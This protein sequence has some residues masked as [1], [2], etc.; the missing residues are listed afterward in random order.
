MNLD[1]LNG[2]ALALSLTLMLVQLGVREKRSVHLMFAVFCGS[3][4][5]MMAKR[6]GADSLGPYQYLLGLGACATCNGYW[7]VARSLFR[8][9]AGVSLRHLLL[10]GVV[11]LLLINDQGLQAM[12]AWGLL[13]TGALPAQLALDEV[14]GLLSSALLVLAFGEACRGWRSANRSD[15]L[16][17]TAFLICYGGSVLLCT[18][19]PQ[20]LRGMQ[21]QGLS[22][23]MFPALCAVIMLLLTQV[24]ILRRYPAV[25]SG[26]SDM[27]LMPERAAP[28]HAA[29]KNVASPSMAASIA[30]IDGSTGIE[31]SRDID[32]SNDSDD[33]ASTPISAA[34]QALAADVQTVLRAE[35][36]YLQA[37]LKLLDLARR[38]GVPEYRISRAIRLAL[39]G[40]NF[41][42]FVNQLRVQHA[43]E[44]L[45]A[46]DK[47]HW[48]VLVVGMESGF[49]SAGPFTR[50]FKAETGLTPG[51]FRQRQ[52][53][54]MAAEP[55]S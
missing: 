10:A 24:L 11:G 7:L 17:R 50:A 52:R 20:V 33:P 6:L 43:V 13:Q 30:D 16:Q 31:S 25:S 19:G 39:G 35:R 15:R 8:G 9:D 45:R 37:D 5:M 44:L 1:I 46:S 34:E 40:R 32:S 53:E 38:F 4:A 3:M 42:Q 14:L 12:R 18:A 49:A 47:Q 23:A 2:L 26:A 29:S 21:L 55:I 36:L 27:S 22:P 28:E 51:E 41:N 48:P 54:T